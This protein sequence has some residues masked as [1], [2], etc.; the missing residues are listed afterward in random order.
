MKKL[1]LL[2]KEV[3][4]NRIKES[5]KTNNN[6]FIIKFSGLSSPDM[7]TLRQEL[8][9][10]CATLFVAKN[11]LLRRVFKDSQLEALVGSIE[12]PCGLVFSKDEP[13]VATGVLYNFSKSHEQ[14]KLE[15]GFLSGKI[16]KKTEIERLAKLPSKDILRAQVV[17]A[18]I[19]PISGLVYVLSGNLKKLVYCL[20]QI[21]KK[22]PN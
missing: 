1:G 6:V 16:L 10:S 8:T 2:F 15:G 12:G 18:L 13:V 21:K 4:A 20:G 5:L 11:S 22:K 17:G 14:L 19:S 3:S 7:T 9:G